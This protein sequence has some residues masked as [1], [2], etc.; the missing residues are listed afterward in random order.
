MYRPPP[1][2][3]GRWGEAAGHRDA[4]MTPSY[5]KRQSSRG[6]SLR[7]CVP[8]GSVDRHVAITP[9]C[10]APTQRLQDAIERRERAS[11]RVSNDQRVVP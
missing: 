6:V 11:R 9:P 4:G 8:I 7:K 1:V 3:A 2:V 5:E 10:V